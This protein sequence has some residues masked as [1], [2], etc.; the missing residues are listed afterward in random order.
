MWDSDTDHEGVIESVAERDAVGV[1]DGGRDAELDRESDGVTDADSEVDDVIDLLTD[2]EL[3]TETEPEREAEG[4]LDAEGVF[5]SVLEGVFVL[6]MER[7][8][9]AA[10]FRT[11]AL[12]G[13][14][15]RARTARARRGSHRRSRRADPACRPPEVDALRSDPQPAGKTTQE[16]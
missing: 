15:M 12:V 13:V 3:V 5:V 4:S 7:L 2:L 10:T 11:S 16:T 6:E 1:V 8:A 9:D 14:H